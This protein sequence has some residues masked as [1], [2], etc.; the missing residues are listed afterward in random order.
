MVVNPHRPTAQDR[1]QLFALSLDML[2]VAGLDGYFKRLNPA[3]ETI[4]GFTTEELLAAPFLEFV[5]PDDHDATL[6][7]VAR[8]AAGAQTIAFENRYRCQDGSYKWL[9]WTAT[10]DPELPLLYAAA[11]DITARKQDEAKIREQAALLNVATDAILVCDL[12]GQIL[13]WNRGAEELYGWSATEA[14]GQNG[15]SLLSPNATQ[16]E[17]EQIQTH[18]LNQGQ[19]QGE[20][21]QAT[22]GQQ[23]LIVASRWTV[24][25]DADG[26][27]KSILIVNTNI[28]EKKQLETQFLRIQ[29]LESIGTLAGGI[30]HDLN[31]ILAPI[32]SIAQLLPLKIPTADEQIQ[33]LF[34]LLQI[35]ARRGGELVKQILTFARGME[36]KNTVVQIRPIILDIQRILR[37][38]FPPNIELSVNIAPD[39]WTT[40]GDTTQLYQVLMNLCVNAK[41]AM[42]TGG[43]LE[44]LARNFEIDESYARMNLE[45]EVGQYLA[46]TISDTGTGIPPMLLERIFEPF[47]TTKE[48][49]QG[50]GLGLP[51][52]M[53]IVKKHSGFLKIYSEVGHGTQVRVFL[54][55]STLQ[56]TASEQEMDLPMGQQELVLV[57]DDEAPIR[58]I[59]QQT[60]ETYN[61]RVVTAEDGIEA[62]ATYV[63]N[64][65]RVKVVLM[66]MMMPQMEGIMAIKTLRKIN[67]QLQIVATSGLKVSDK[68]S[69]AFEEGVKGF[70]LKPYTAEEL[71]TTLQGVL[72][73]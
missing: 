67:P 7:E 2:C 29:R 20:L 57:V 33:Q 72:E 16:A 38:T 30:A 49:Q 27:L 32:L 35:N 45:A 69:V 59:T 62:I 43:R 48:S 22:K 5:H 13:F 28:T 47:F 10:P 56:A 25:R 66:D 70:L 52:A 41:D 19:W 26:Q 4:L 24:V 15:R 11:R 8:L 51:T 58:E 54:P 68:I 53:T 55:A 39:L 34:E 17:F 46:I 40:Y 60:L 42:P 1:E 18:L 73:D 9:L 71:I 6:A 3:F 37:E 14:L 65:A 12:V 50:T 36:S 23:R 31:N 21:H 44:V 61:Y 63:Q 64:Q